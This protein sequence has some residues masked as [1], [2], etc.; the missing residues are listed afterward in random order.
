MDQSDEKPDFTVRSC[1]PSIYPHLRKAKQGRILKLHDSLFAGQ[2]KMYLQAQLEFCLPPSAS[3]MLFAAP[4]IRM[5]CL[6]P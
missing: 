1:F 2:G 4:K 6:S 5:T 3:L